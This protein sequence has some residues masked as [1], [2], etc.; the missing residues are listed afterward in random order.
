VTFGL[1]LLWPRGPDRAAGTAAGAAAAVALLL[2]LAPPAQAGE[3]APADAERE[4]SINL[5]RSPSI[6]LEYRWRALS[7]HAGA[8]PTIVEP[9]ARGISGTTL[10]LRT[11]LRADLWTFHPTSAG[12]SALFADVSYVRGL[13]DGWRNGLLTEL[14]VRL[15]IW[16]GLEARLGAALLLAEGHRPRL[17]PTPGLSWVVPL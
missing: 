2:A 3:P 17:N 8:Y 14:G 15:R 7:V 5:F 1:V 16:S 10:F 13:N 11:G 12:R 6:G 9:G 4:L